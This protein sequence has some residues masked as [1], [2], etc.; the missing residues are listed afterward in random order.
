M[1]SCKSVPLY[2]KPFLIGFSASVIEYINQENRANA[3]PAP[4]AYFYCARNTTEPERADPEEV[5]RSLLEQLS[6]SD[7][8]SPIRNPVVRA[9]EEK[10][11]EAKGRKPER[12]ALD[13]IVDVILA[14]LETNPATIV[15]DA[16]DECDPARRQDLFLALRKIIQKSANLVKVFVSSRDDH[17]IVHRLQNSPNLYIHSKDNSEDIG[18]FVHWQVIRAIEEEKLICGNVSESL[19]DQVIE[20]LISKAEGMLVTLTCLAHSGDFHS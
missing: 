12:L 9:Y 10:K 1:C 11:K 19:R 5:L 3:H 17:D 15:I 16:L 6:S 14:L 2:A 13:E 7:E 18:H 4:I 20:T 8:D